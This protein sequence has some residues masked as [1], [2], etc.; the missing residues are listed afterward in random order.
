MANKYYE[1]AKLSQIIM[2]LIYLYQEMSRDGHT[3]E[4]TLKGLI[5]TINDL[6]YYHQFIK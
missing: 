4:G 6:K 5:R 3:D 1:K 2:D